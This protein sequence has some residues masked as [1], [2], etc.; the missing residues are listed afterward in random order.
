MGGFLP[1]PDGFSALAV[2]F[3]EGKLV[4]GVA[5]LGHN[6]LQAVLAAEGHQGIGIG[7]QRL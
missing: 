6:A 2:G 7:V 1:A 5:P 3:R 4:E